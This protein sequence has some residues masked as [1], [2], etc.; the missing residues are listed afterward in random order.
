MYSSGYTL[1]KQI[2]LTY[3]KAKITAPITLS[4]NEMEE[5]SVL[6]K[7][8]SEWFD[9][10]GITADFNYQL[11]RTTQSKN[12]H[13]TSISD[14]GVMLSLVTSGGNSDEPFDGQLKINNIR[15]RKGES[16]DNIFHLKIVTTPYNNDGDNYQNLILYDV[17]V[18]VSLNV[19]D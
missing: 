14:V 5:T 15:A 6:Y 12:S 13:T 16:Q 2:D 19:T 11:F 1:E 4:V 10:L 7:K 18:T 17:A 3:Y 8:L 9:Q